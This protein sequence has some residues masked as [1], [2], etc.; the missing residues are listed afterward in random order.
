MRLGLLADSH[1]RLPALRA[2]LAAFEERG[3][4]L[5][6]H[7]GDFCAPFALE[8][9]VAGNIPTVGV[10]GRT[11]G[12]REGLIATAARGLAVE[13]YESPHSITVGDSS[14]LLVHDIGDVPARSLAGHAYVVHGSLHRPEMKARGESVYICPGEVCGWVNGTPGAAVLDLDTKDVEFLKLSGPEWT[15]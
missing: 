5:I 6:L 11:D 1:D 4:E 13:L 9:L 7:A 2:M 15:T 3:V 8:P 12:D 14:I 10:F